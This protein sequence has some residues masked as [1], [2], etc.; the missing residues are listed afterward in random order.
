[1]EEPLTLKDDGT[2]QQVFQSPQIDY[3]YRSPWNE[4]Y[5]ERSPD[6]NLDLHLKG[7]RYYASG[8]ELGESSGRDWGDEDSPF[9]FYNADEDKI[10]EM[11]DKVI[12]RVKSDKSS[13]GGIVLLQMQ[14]DPDNGPERFVLKQKDD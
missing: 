7:M 10:I 12:L 8:I 3:F 11:I 1:M 13:P 2:Y 6:G 5:V 9:P 4:W 14:V